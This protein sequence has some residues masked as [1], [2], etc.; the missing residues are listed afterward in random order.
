MFEPLSISGWEPASSSVGLG[1]GGLLGLG[2]AELSSLEHRGR[3][4]LD[5]LLRADAHEV[6]GD[7]HELLADRDMTLSDEHSSVM[8]GV[9]ELPLG[10]DGLESSLHHL[11]EGQSEHVIE[12][13]LVFLEEAESNHSSDEGITYINN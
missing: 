9:G 13:F 11:G 10:D 5:V 6:A 2:S 3:G 4:E 8:H 12:L 1:G 7:V